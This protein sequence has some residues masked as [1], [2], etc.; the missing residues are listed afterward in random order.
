MTSPGGASTS[1]KT[2]EGICVGRIMR[3]RKGRL[4]EMALV[5]R[6]GLPAHAR[7]A[8]QADTA[9][10]N[11]RSNPFKLG[12]IKSNLMRSKPR[13]PLLTHPWGIIPTHRPNMATHHR[14]RG[15]RFGSSNLEIKPV[16]NPIPA[17]MAKTS[18]AGTM[19]RLNAY[20]AKAPRPMAIASTLVTSTPSSKEGRDDLEAFGVIISVCRLIRSSVPEFNPATS[21]AHGYGVGRQIARQSDLWS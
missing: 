9:P 13:I 17:A 11:N 18:T 4:C 12:S 15:L 10:K 21:W 14:T 2:L 3:F 1:L 20:R 19:P 16:I 8:N 7:T 5:C 6:E